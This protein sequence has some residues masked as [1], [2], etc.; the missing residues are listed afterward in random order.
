MKR[1]LIQWGTGVTGQHVVRTLLRD[2]DYELVGC[3]TTTDSK[4][5]RD[6]GDIC[7]VGPVGV[8]AS[9]DREAIYAMPADI[10]LYMTLEEFGLDKPVQE[11]CRLLESG[12][13]VLSTAATVLIYPKAAGQAVFD[14]IDAAGKRGGTTFHATGVEPGWAAEVLPLILSGM[15]GR[16]DSLLVQEIIDYAT[17]NSAAGMFDL[18]RFGT[19]FDPVPPTEL[20]PYKAG[21]FGAPLLMVADAMGVIIDKVVYQ[22][23]LAYADES[24]DIAAGR[25]EAGTV[26]GKRYSFTAYIAGE[27]RLKIEHVTR[28]GAHVKPD[29]PKGQGWYV[30]AHG[31]PSMRLSAEI[32]IDGGE[33]PN[34]ASYAAAMRVIN[35]IPYVCEA[36]AG[37]KTLLDMPMIIGRGILTRNV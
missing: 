4:N 33:P 1:K 25:I 22:C 34:E 3:Y 35:T 21:P 28:A 10:V 17:Y 36:G 2:P 9:T 27:P 11:I 5:G 15:L 8:Q 6:L 24:Y 37:V 14:R 30:T 29:W 13:N 18:M 32:A 7:G 31:K 23:E 12:K 19:K 16:A 26:S 20:D